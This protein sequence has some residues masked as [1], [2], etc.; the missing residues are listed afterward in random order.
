MH[1]CNVKKISSLTHQRSIE[2]H[3]VVVHVCNYQEVFTQSINKYTWHGRRVRIS[4]VE[5]HRTAVQ[6]I[7]IL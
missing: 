1:A 5:I 4:I 2:V 3:R 7:V 6:K